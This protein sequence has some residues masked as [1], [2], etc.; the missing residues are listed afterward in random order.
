MMEG[1]NNQSR[2]YQ[3]KVV[4]ID[5]GALYQI[6]LRVFFIGNEMLVV[7][8]ELWQNSIVVW[9]INVKCHNPLLVTGLFLYPLKTWETEMFSYVFR[10]YRKRLVV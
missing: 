3:F 8:E 1:K 9:N 7:N 5:V 2:N 4:D 6:S 10:G